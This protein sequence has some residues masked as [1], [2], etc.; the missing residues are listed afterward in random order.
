MNISYTQNSDLNTDGMDEELWDIEFNKASINTILLLSRLDTLNAQV[1]SLS[2]L[3]R[4][5]DSL[6][7]VCSS[8][9]LK[10]VEI[11]TD[12]L[13]EFRRKFNEAEEYVIQNKNL[14]ENSAIQHFDEIKR[15]KAVCLPEFSQRYI[16]LLEQIK[17]VFVTEVNQYTVIEGDCLTLIAEKVYKNPK[18]WKLIWKANIKEVINSAELPDYKKRISNPN[19]IYPSQI[20]KIPHPEN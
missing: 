16:S 19:K 1:D 6:E 15:S 8:Q 7:K 13:D 18:L 12:E 5:L 2:V 10:N 3:K 14:T 20:I 17:K 11:T 9:I 4:N